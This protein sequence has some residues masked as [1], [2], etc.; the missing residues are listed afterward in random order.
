MRIVS[1]SYSSTK[2]FTDPL[3]WLERID[4]YT[5]ILDQLAQQHDV[6]SI[7][8]IDYEGQHK[9]NG[10]QYYFYRLNNRVAQFPAR[11]HRFLKKLKP[12]VVLV[13][14][15]VFPLQVMQLRLKLGPAVKIILVHRS[16]RPAK[17]FRKMLQRIADKFVDAYLFTSAEFGEQWVRSGNITGK[18]HEVL[19]GS[20]VFTP[21]GKETARA[22]LSIN[23]SPVFLWVGRLDANKDPLTVIKA[24]KRF[25]LV[26]PTACLF[27][28]YQKEELL[29]EVKVEADA[30]EN[31]KLIGKVA[32]QA[33]ANW[34][35]A[36]DYLIAASHYEG[37]GISVCE[38]LSCGCIPILSDIVSFR[39]LS[40]RGQCG[41]SFEPGKEQELFNA[42]MKTNSLDIERERTKVLQQFSNE[43]S[44]K[45]IGR[46]IESVM[47]SLDKKK[48]NG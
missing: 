12:D 43:L 7:E 5:G 18:Y 19:H 29:E 46:K 23:N 35:N 26:Q 32:H 9:Q 22:A 25:L 17:G 11:L 28:I 1:T 37:G 10:V 40:G 3:K 48:G 38:A 27:M 16:E 15:L 36:A 41:L 39:T 42:L 2:S 6:T 33:L 44:F 45:A 31:I 21:T 20:S 47:Q 14:G 13:N 4:F 8:R 34:Y 30:I 24:F